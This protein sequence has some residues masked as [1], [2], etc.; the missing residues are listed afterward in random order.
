[1]CFGIPVIFMTLRMSNLLFEHHMFIFCSDY[2]VQGH[3]F[4]LFEDIGC[5][6]A[7]YI[8]A[9]ALCLV[10]I[11]PIMISLASFFYAGQHHYL[12]SN[13]PFSL[14]LTLFFVAKSL[15]HILR[16]RSEFARHLNSHTAIS[17]GRYFRL[18][19]LAV[20]V[21]VWDTGINAY[22]I[23]YDISLG[24]L[25]YVNWEFVHFNF[26]RIQQL[27]LFILPQ[28]VK[29]QLHFQW[30]IPPATSLTFFIFFGFG[31]EAMSNYRTAFRWFRRTV[32][33]QNI[34]KSSSPGVDVL[35]SYQCVFL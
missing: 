6:P 35:P 27:P 1:M 13:S 29:D 9:P 11:P 23:Y 30:W 25:P 22:I 12:Q 14:V 17:S 3:R 31:T 15:R 18:M 5:T 28:Y 26:S 20:T 24:L 8:S 4:D 32:L 2:I 10:L 33:R 16:H 19:A 34:R 21:T 7:T